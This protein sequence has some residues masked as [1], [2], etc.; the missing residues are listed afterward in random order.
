MPPQTTTTKA[1]TMEHSGGHHDSFRSM[2]LGSTGNT[3]D[4]GDA[5]G[6]DNGHSNLH[7]RNTASWNMGYTNPTF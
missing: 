7:G 5:N 3:Q 2:F 1:T 6:G 4:N